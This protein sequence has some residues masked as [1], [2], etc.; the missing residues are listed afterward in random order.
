MAILGVQI[1]VTMITASV[2]S[3]IG[4]FKSVGRWLLTSS[5]LVRYC[6]PT[7]EELKAYAPS[8][9]GIKRRH[10]KQQQQQETSTFNVPRNIN[11]ELETAPIRPIDVVQ[12]RFYS[13]YQWLLDF[14]IYAIFVYIFTEL[15]TFVMPDRIQTEIN[16]SLVWC[17]LVVGFSYW[18]L[19]SL[20]SLYF[21]GEESTG[22]RSL[23]IVM[24]F[25]YLF[26]AMMILIVQ[27]DTLESGLDEAY[28]SFNMSAAAFLAENTGLDSSG[29]ASKLVLKFFLAIWCSSIGA[30]FTF[31]G[32]RI[33]RMQWDVLKY[34]ESQPSLMV[35]HA[36]FISPLLLTTLWVR[37]LSRDYLT[38]RVFKGMEGPLM[39]ESQFES[40]RL[41]LIIAVFLLR[42]WVMP[43]YLQS[44]LNIAY[45]K[46]EEM[47]TEAGK[48][49]NI[50][51]QKMVARIF[52]YLCVVTLQYLAPMI[53]ILF[54]S[55]MYKTMGEG[56]TWT[57]LWVERSEETCSINEDSNTPFSKLFEQK[58]VEAVTQQV[59]LAWQSLKQV[60]SI[61]MC[62]GVLGF[63][64]WWCCFIWFVS[65][66]IGI[67]Y[68]SYFAEV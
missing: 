16:L 17:I 61:A 50:N 34:T 35:L 59:S 38:I 55:L 37:P 4:P 49:S 6:H 57:G 26:F 67:A 22:E 39:T 53:L 28:K 44:Y 42:L 10:H 14:S 68:Q 66:A 5:G 47:K 40:M 43:R 21:E 48:I 64:T 54:L 62:K 19:L 13:E 33:A 18:I 11:V 12:L 1:V 45:H 60:F 51:L 24:A 36:A 46:M 23:V 29:P 52:Y 63:T 15:Y 8:V 56:G 65:S 9:N 7:D 58:D 20:S 2:M 32:L 31:P 27:E 25:V 41:Y 3:K 30:L